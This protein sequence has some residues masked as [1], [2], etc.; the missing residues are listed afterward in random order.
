MTKPPSHEIQDVQQRSLGL[1]A[2]LLVVTL[3]IYWFYLGYQWSKEMNGLA[4]R[5]KYPPVLLLVINIVTLGLAGLAY[6]CIWAYDIAQA[7]QSRG[8]PGH[9]QGLPLWVIVLNAVG[10]LLSLTGIGVV[11]GFP[12]GVAASLLVQAELNKLAVSVPVMKEAVAV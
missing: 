3:G 8:V 10:L 5:V 7:A 1:V 12:M 2:L 6:E 9:S 4:G 11:L